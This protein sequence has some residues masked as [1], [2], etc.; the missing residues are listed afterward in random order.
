MAD[1]IPDTRRRKVLFLSNSDRG[2]VGVTVAAAQAI[3]ESAS[4]SSSADKT[5]VEVH[6]ATFAGV[7]ELISKVSTEALKANPAA[8]PIVYHN[9][10]RVGTSE[11]EM[12]SLLKYLDI[13]CKPNYLPWSFLTKPSFR[14]TLRALRDTLLCL[15]PM[16]G[17]AM[18]KIVLQIL[19]I[20]AGVTPDLIVVNS[21]MTPGLTAAIHSGLPTCILSPNSI[22]EFAASLQPYGA[23]LWKYPA[24][25]SGFSYPIPWYQR[26]INVLY[27]LWALKVFL[28]DPHRLAVERHL[29]S[30]SG[31]TLRTPAELIKNRFGMQILVASLPELDF[32]MTIPD[33]VHPCGPILGRWQPIQESDPELY[34][35]L[36][37]APT[38]YINLGSLA[39]TDEESA[40]EMAGAIKLIMDRA[41]QEQE[42]GGVK[43]QK[44]LQVIWKLKKLGEYE[45]KK[46]KCAM[47]DILGPEIEAD[48]VRI[49]KWFIPE[50]LSI[51]QSGHVVCAV[52]H[53]GAN[54]FNEAVISGLPHVVLPPWTDCYD[55]ALRAELHGLGRW[56]SRKSNPQWAAHELADAMSWCLFGETARVCRQKTKAM[57]ELVKSRGNGAAKAAEFIMGQVDANVNAAQG[58][59]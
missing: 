50:P 11:E 45:T 46:P 10:A 3:L 17:P 59:T 51:L 31:I 40:L 7:E 48:R 58:R 39:A 22:K 44:G 18:E 57:A 5:P 21:V 9:I 27:V 13:P 12:N 54:S 32:P 2:E 23:V 6:I 25:W 37:R 52:H 29:K 35:W 30:S 26:P 34:S 41:Q 56:G 1:P 4:L 28:T 20:I 47:Y 19:D 53:G 24:S 16:P 14:N 8:L 15:V 55:Y 42:V 43:G 36:S 33:H 38:L 49:E